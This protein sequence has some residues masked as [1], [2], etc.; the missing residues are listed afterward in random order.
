V[1]KKIG[2]S[3]IIL[4]G[5]SVILS[6][7]KDNSD[8]L[9]EL[10]KELEDLRDKYQ[11]EITI[12]KEIE[13]VEEVNNLETDSSAHFID[14]TKEFSGDLLTELDNKRNKGFLVQDNTVGINNG[15]IVNGGKDITF[16]EHKYED[17][18]LELY[19]EELD[20]IT[21]YEKKNSNN[22]LFFLELPQYEIDSYEIV[23]Y[24]NNNKLENLEN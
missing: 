11:V 8:N 23:V 20:V 7:C 13:E 3:I 19:F 18:K 22:V 2:S 1:N 17:N 15:E 21:N 5:I 4:L 14:V 6:G 9:S 16:I 10:D 24:V 12:D